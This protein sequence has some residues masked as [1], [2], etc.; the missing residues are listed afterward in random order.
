[1]EDDEVTTVSGIEWIVLN[2]SLTNHVE[3]SA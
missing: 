2:G 3:I 1:M